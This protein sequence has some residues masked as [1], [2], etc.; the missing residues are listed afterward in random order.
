[1]E[2]TGASFERFCFVALWERLVP[3]GVSNL[4][5]GAG[6]FDS[7]DCGA[8]IINRFSCII[9]PSYYTPRSVIP[10]SVTAN[11]CIHCQFLPLQIKLDESRDFVFFVRLSPKVHGR[12]V[13]RMD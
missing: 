1:M 13:I 3:L 9:F 5:L 10:R 4:D 11:I 7:A 2:G 12:C 6:L 8:L